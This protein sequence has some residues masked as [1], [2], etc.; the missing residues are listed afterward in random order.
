M[1]SQNISTLYFRW[2]TRFSFLV[3]TKRLYKRVCPSVGPSVRWSVGPS[4]RPSVGDAL[5]IN[6]ENQYF[7]ANDCKGRHTRQISCNHII[8]QSF[9]H[10]EDVLLALWALFIFFLFRLL[11]LHG[12]IYQLYIW[13]TRERDLPKQSRRVPSDGRPS[14]ATCL[15]E[16]HREKRWTGADSENYIATFVPLVLSLS[17]SLSLFFPKSAM[18][19]VTAI[20][21][22]SG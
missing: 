19:S 20:A 14:L 11:F 3:A 21:S 17:P 4:V 7:Q 9:H 13:S 10:H 8:I 2:K 18:A 16:E 6:K 15:S 12:N 22:E 5:V 1:F